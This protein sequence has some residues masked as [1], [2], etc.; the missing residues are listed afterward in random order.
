MIRL[1]SDAG[2]PIWSPTN[3]KLVDTTP[4]TSSYLDAPLTVGQTLTDPVSHISITTLSVD[5]SGASIRVT[6]SVAPSAPAALGGVPFGPHAVDLSWSAATDNI[7][8]TGYRLQRDGVG[9]GDAGPVRAGLSR[10]R[11]RD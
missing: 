9:R 1:S 3:T 10:R 6:E 11:A 2:V 8:V 4:G 7:A 5:A